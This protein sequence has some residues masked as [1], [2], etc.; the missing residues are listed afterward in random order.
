MSE[1]LKVASR[2]AVAQ[3]AYAVFDRGTSTED[4][5]TQQSRSDF[6]IAQATRFVSSPDD[7]AGFKLLHHQANDAAGFSA[8]VFLDKTANR[9]VL[10]IRGTE[11]VS[12][13]I[14]D[15]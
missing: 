13:F 8:S 6:T 10:S 11:G 4:A 12:D 9:F 3:A 2:S 7:G 5:L 14:E 1:T 15:I